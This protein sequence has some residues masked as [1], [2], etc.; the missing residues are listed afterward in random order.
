MRK[1]L[2]WLTLTGDT[3]YCGGGGGNTVAGAHSL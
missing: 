3:V 2:F 1:D